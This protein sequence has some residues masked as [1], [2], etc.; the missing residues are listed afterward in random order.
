M[1]ASYN[2]NRSRRA[3]VRYVNREERYKD[4]KDISPFSFI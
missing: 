3:N 2:A 4:I 1:L